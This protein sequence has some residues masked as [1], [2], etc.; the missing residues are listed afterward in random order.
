MARRNNIKLS[1]LVN[2]IR[3]NL[4]NFLLGLT[5]LIVF[6]LLSSLYLQSGKKM[7]SPQTKQTQPSKPMEEKKPQTKTTSLW[8]MI[9][10]K[11]EEKPKKKSESKKYTVKEGD[12][13]WVIAE[14]HY[15]SGY[16]AYD[17]AQANSMENPDTV[18]VGITLEIPEV[19]PKQATKGEVGAMMTE[20]PTISGS[21]YIVK[22][23]DSL[24]TIAL[25]AYGDGYLWPRLAQANNLVNPDV[26]TPGQKLTLPR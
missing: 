18:E 3:A 12:S 24:W 13:L 23:G 22:E 4:P 20:K 1:S 2:Q 17:I 19:A 14:K 8:D 6:V 9:M 26:L 11:K 16:N 10:G 21:E 7:S 15:G 25:G 5:I